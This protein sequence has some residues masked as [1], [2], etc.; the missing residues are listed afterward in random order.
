MIV[1]CANKCTLH[2]WIYRILMYLIPWVLHQKRFLHCSNKRR[3][4]LIGFFGEGHPFVMDSSYTVYYGKDPKG[5]GYMF[6]G[7][8][9]AYW[10]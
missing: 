3:T 1:Y 10:Y 5:T 6:E 9:G 2:P 4:Y 8:A 7:S